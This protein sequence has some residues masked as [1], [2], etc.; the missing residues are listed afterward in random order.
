MHSEASY[1]LTPTAVRPQ[2]SSTGRR[3]IQALLVAIACVGFLASGWTFHPRDAGYGTHQQWDL[4]ACSFLATSGWPCPSCGLT[5][6]VS[7]TV[8]G[9]FLLALKAQPFGV[10]LVA[11]VALATLV[12]L[13]SAITGRIPPEAMLPRWWW[14]LLTVAALMAGWG[15]KVWSGI[16]AN[17]LPIH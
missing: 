8:Q 4:P 13:A 10:V 12:S 3:R 7:A 6:S 2:F 11:A 17:T 9:K 14:A 5:T 16:A 1:E 15:I